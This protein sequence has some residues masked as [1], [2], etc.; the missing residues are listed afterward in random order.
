LDVRSGQ[1]GEVNTAVSAAPPVGVPGILFSHAQV[2][3]QEAFPPPP[4]GTWVARL[5]ASPAYQAQKDLAPKNLPEEAAVARCLDALDRSGGT[6]TPT[7]LAQQVGI[8]P[9]HLDGFL[10]RLQRLLNVD[11]YE[12]L[13]FDRAQN[14]VAL[15]VALLRGQFEVD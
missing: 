1:S 4:G 8:L 10:A 5:L 13:V 9:L 15:N 12:V 7:A 11:G 3:G 14:S 2:G 6:L